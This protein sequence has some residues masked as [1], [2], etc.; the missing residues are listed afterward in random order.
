MS[1][2][3][4]WWVREQIE[5]KGADWRTWP[6]ATR[7]ALLSI[8]PETLAAAGLTT[9]PAGG[10]GGAAPCP[11]PDKGHLLDSSDQDGVP[12]ATCSCG[13]D[14]DRTCTCSHDDDEGLVDELDDLVAVDRRRRATATDPRAP[15][16][17]RGRT[18]ERRSSD[19]MDELA[20]RAA[21]EDATNRR[22]R[23]GKGEVVS[24]NEDGWVY[25]HVRVVD[26]FRFR[27][28]TCKVRGRCPHC[29]RAYA[30]E[31]A[32]ELRSLL[33]AALERRRRPLAEHDPMG[34]AFVVTMPR[35]ISAELGRLADDPRER[36]ALRA[37][38][39]RLVGVARDYVAGMLRRDPRELGM[40]INVHWWA[41]E[42]PTRER[43]HWHAHVMVPNV[44]RDGDAV[45]RRAKLTPQELRAGREKLG[46]LLRRAFPTVGGEWRPNAHARW[47]LAD[48][49]GRRRWRHRSRY[50]ARHPFADALKVARR[51]PWEVFGSDAAPALERFALRVEELQRLK[52]R[53][54]VGFLVPGRR[55]VVGLVKDEASGDRE[56]VALEDGYRRIRRWTRLGLELV[57]FDRFT[58]EAVS[59]VLAELVDF[60][61]M[62]PP[63]RWS[64]DSA[65][66]AGRKVEP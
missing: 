12:A 1:S 52:L 8:D 25:K 59:E 36:K 6:D 50:D 19:R 45:R 47:F 65:R 13:H 24:C 5:A 16:G 18:W 23:D 28:H 20:L 39:T 40:A 17:E 27:V 66:D 37:G 29:G 2:R 11:Y 10:A 46:G 49:V 26:A 41:S 35:A 58:G 21:I 42:N 15:A 38:V 54:Y 62:G 51:R 22:I 32:S 56:W 48:A 14:A 33:G 60:D 57:R 9:G 64:Y 55:K 4:A 53:R 61:S 43:W 7:A 3:A 44:T 30:L 31:Q 63:V 34:W